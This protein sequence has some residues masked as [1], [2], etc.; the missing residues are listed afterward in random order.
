MDKWWT[1]NFAELVP[2]KLSGDSGVKPLILNAEFHGV[3]PRMRVIVVMRPCTGHRRT[4]YGYEVARKE[5][6]AE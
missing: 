1:I 4:T 3:K 6:L 5:W 2:W